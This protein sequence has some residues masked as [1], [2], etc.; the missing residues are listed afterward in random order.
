MKDSAER[1][2]SSVEIGLHTSS[3]SKAIAESKR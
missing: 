3:D 2:A 1:F